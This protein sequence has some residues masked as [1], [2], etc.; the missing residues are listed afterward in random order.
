MEKIQLEVYAVT[1][2]QTHS[3][4]YALILQEKRGNRRLPIII[5]TNEAQA[6]A[7]KLEDLKPQRPLTHDLFLT[8]ATSFG[9]QLVEVNIVKLQQAVF[10]SELVCI[11]D[12]TT[13]RLDARTSDAVALALRF[14][15]PIYTN[16][17][18]MKEAGVDIGFFQQDKNVV[19]SQSYSQLSDAKL[20]NFFQK[21]IEEE[22]Y[23]DAS[24]IRDEL[25][26]RGYDKF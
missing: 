7:I 21:A 26:R 24:R 1:H 13:I 3:G 25:K 11:K 4:A 17:K 23:E 16:E 19:E 18:V 5:G 9:V 10:Y 6:I 20:K 8:L 15:C 14:N 22:R 2:S 12:S